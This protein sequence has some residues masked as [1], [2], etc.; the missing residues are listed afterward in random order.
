VSETVSESATE[1]LALEQ[2]PEKLAVVRLGPGAEVPGWA[3]SSSLFSITATARETSI[4]CAARSVPRKA[5]QAGP[6]IAFAVQ[7]P[8]DFSLTGILATLLQPLADAEISVFTIATFDTDWILVPLDDAERAAE[9]W[10]RRGHAVAPAVP[11]TP[12][13]QKES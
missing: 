3:E 12:E 10:R 9:E 7:G 11:V 5:Q 8:L 2:F 1:T 13:E 4:V 6:F